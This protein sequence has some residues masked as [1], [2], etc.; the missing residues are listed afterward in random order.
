MW[1]DAPRGAPAASSEGVRWVPAAS[2][3]QECDAQSV[4]VSRR[5]LR[6]APRPRRR[7]ASPPGGRAVFLRSVF[8][9][10]L[11]RQILPY[12]ALRVETLFFKIIK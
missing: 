5:C 11:H 12:L 2:G 9:D 10:P 8:S 7:L 6:S 3:R 4:G 1:P